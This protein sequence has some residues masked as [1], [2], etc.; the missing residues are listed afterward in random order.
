MERR[1]S[2]QY[3]RTL[4][5]E[6]ALSTPGGQ[7]IDKPGQHFVPVGAIKP[8]SQLGGQQSVFSSDVVSA[9]PDLVREVAFPSCQAGERGREGE[10][11]VIPG[12]HF[13]EQIK[14]RRGQDVHAKKAQVI[15]GTQSRNNQ[16]LFRLGWSR[17]FKYIHHFEET[18]VATDQ[19]ASDRSKVGKL[20]FVSG[21]DC[22]DNTLMSFGDF[23]ELTGA[24]SLLTAHVDVISDQKQEWVSANEIPP[25]RHRVGVPP[26]LSLFDKV[27][28]PRMNTGCS[29]I[30]G[31]IAGVNHDADLIDPS[32]QRLFNDDGKGGLGPAVAVDQ[33]LQR[34][35]SLRLA[36]GGD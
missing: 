10:S 25:A 19:P 13:R 2:W 23:D 33:G 29:R 28:T 12:E 9:A 26:R 36:S 35:S 5:P 4:R 24:T 7:Q 20:A 27:E 11:G 34:E 14:N 32:R 3:S 15:S 21:L 22:G 17:F 6:F 1:V 8:E 18:R 16:S 30:G 31:L